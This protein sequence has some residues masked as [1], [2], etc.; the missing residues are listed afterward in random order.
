MTNEFTKK[1][2]L[3]EKKSKYSGTNPLKNLLSLL[4]ANQIKP[5][6][7]FSF[8]DATVDHLPQS[9]IKD[10][11]S[12]FHSSENKYFDQYFR[13]KCDGLIGD[14]IMQFNH[15]SELSQR[16][17]KL[18]EI[19]R[20]FVSPTQYILSDEMQ[21]FLTKE[22]LDSVKMLIHT[23]VHE[24]DRSV[25]L[26]TSEPGKWVDIATHFCDH[27]DGVY[28]ISINELFNN[29]TKKDFTVLDEEETIKKV[30]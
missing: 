16:D 24:Q 9:Q 13:K 29:Y 3:F 19:Y 12:L 4:K 20:S 2:I 1:L 27:R 25:L 30:S 6:K 26:T 5:F 17:K 18:I 15:L 7:N 11:I 8:I 28:N 23:I 14:I 10:Y 22:D 21:K